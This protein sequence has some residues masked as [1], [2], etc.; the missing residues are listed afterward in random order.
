M[1]AIH[2]YLVAK[3]AKRYR[4]LFA[5]RIAETVSVRASTRSLTPEALANEFRRIDTDAQDGKLSKDELWGFISSGKAG[6]MDQKDFDALFA[7]VDLDKNGTVDFLEFCAFM[8]K[9]DE[10]YRAA[11]LDRED[12]VA[13]RS[14]RANLSET[15]A[16]RIISYELPAPAEEQGQNPDPDLSP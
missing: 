16:R 3:Q 10:E 1:Y 9:C 6:E 4:V 11:Q 12:L 13:R 14:I 15:T 8:G 5:Q 7:A 2:L